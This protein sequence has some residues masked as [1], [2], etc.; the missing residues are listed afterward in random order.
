MRKFIA[1]LMVVLMFSFSGCAFMCA[2]GPQVVEKLNTTV[3][4]LKILTDQ[5]QLSLLSQYDAE[6]ELAYI[7]AKGSLAAAK[8]LLEQTC[9][10]PT[11]V[12]AVV[13]AAYKVAIPQA[14][15]GAARAK[16]L[17]KGK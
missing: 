2:N 4:T 13:T 11:S 6:V 5:L 3:D 7:A 17:Q 12:D 14:L 15:A 10:D 9:P 1:A 8:T 16:K